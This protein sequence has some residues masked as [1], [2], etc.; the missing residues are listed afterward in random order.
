MGYNGL[1]SVPKGGGG[2]AKHRG[3]LCVFHPVATGLILGIHKNL[4]NVAD[5]Y[6]QGLI[7]KWKEA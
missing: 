7:G 2:A 5:I 3:T 4:F 6:Q 1:K